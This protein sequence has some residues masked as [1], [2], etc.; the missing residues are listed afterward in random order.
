L[1]EGMT[2]LRM[3]ADIYLRRNQLEE[4]GR[5]IQQVG[6]I[7]AETGNNEEALLNLRRAVELTPKDMGLLR[8]VVGFSLRLARQV[9]HKDEKEAAR[10]QAI[11]AQYQAIIARHYFETHQVK[12][13][14][15]ALQ[16]L[17]TIDKSNLE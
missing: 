11:A 17:I 5:A 13:S 6:N 9:E 12:E 8:E 10:Y 14:V 1:E 16:Q 2:E 3:V 4:A 15:A 7:Y